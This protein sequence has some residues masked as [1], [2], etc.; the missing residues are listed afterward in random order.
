MSPS[1]L[2]V[3]LHIYTTNQE[4]AAAN[5]GW[6]KELVEHWKK[7]GVVRQED[8]GRLDCTE[9]GNT[10]VDSIL[11]TPQPVQRW[12]DPRASVTPA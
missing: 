7:D 1:H 10:W 4:H 2:K 3:L 8:D 9:K 6:F 12:L 11:A 5:E